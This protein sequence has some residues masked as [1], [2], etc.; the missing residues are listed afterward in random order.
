VRAIPDLRP[1]SRWPGFILG[2]TC[3][4]L[5]AVLLYHRLPKEDVSPVPPA[6]VQNALPAPASVPLPEPVAAVPT[7][8]PSRPAPAAT[9]RAAP[10]LRERLAEEVRRSEPLYLR[11]AMRHTRRSKVLQ[12]YGRDWM[13]HPDLRKLNDEYFEHHDPVRF[14]YGAASSKNFWNLVSKYS[15]R[16]EILSFLTDAVRAAPAGL[17]SASSEFMKTDKTAVKLYERFARA[18]GLPLDSLLKR[19]P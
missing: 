1:P 6:P 2:L 14:V 11:L 7:A 4:C 8:A 17:R 16:P 15:S 12:Q 3:G 18:S 5:L 10:T 9:R 13:A 19:K